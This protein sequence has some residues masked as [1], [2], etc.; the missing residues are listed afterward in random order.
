MQIIFSQ[1][2]NF[3]ITDGLVS[4]L[5]EIADALK[6]SLF[7]NYLNYITLMLRYTQL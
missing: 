7:Q 4:S 5:V 1:I 3:Q 6:L 2:K